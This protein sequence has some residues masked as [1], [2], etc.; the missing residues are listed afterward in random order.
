[1]QRDAWRTYLELA[2]GLTEKPRKQA[3]K[4]MN[5]V[6]AQS[7][8]SVDQL[9]SLTEELVETSVA[10]REA[11]ARVVRS[12]LDKALERVGLARAEEMNELRDRI[13]DLERRV[14]SEPSAES[15]SKTAKKATKKA[16]PATATK[17]A[18]S[19]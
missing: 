1:M 17:K 10:N 7:G 13:A 14:P 18:A 19:A 15:A 6:A 9:R 8:A 5:A 3:K 12:E 11:L 16:A 2:L 4:V